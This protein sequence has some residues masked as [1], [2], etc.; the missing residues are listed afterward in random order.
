M[1]RVTLKSENTIVLIGDSP[2]Y[3]TS[4]ETGSLFAGVQDVSFSVPQTRQTQKQLGSCYY[5]VDD[6]V[7]HPDIDLNISYIYSPS[8]VNES[9]M[10]LNVDGIVSTGQPFTQEPSGDFISGIDDKSYN[11]YVYNHPEA[12]FDAIEYITSSDINTPNTGEIVSFGNAYLTQYS[13]SFAN[14]ALPVVQTTFK[15]SNVKAENYTGDI[16]SP[17]INLLSGNNNGVGNIDFSETKTISED[18][19]GSGI[20]LDTT[21]PVLS[22]PKDVTL[23]LQNLQVGGQNISGD[24]IV[25]SLSVSI[26]I[27][28]VD[29][30]GLGSDYVRGRK[31][32]YPSRGSISVAS[33]VSKYETGF[34]SGLLKNES[35]YSFVVTAS[36]CDGEIDSK[37]YFDDVKL[38]TFDYSMQTNENMQYSASFSFTM[39]NK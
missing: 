26:P 16:P 36:S 39:D 8:M 38:E 9:L 1:S 7:R 2:S 14:R 10:G 21:K 33:L 37:M 35:K 12:G 5:A 4:N 30:Y 23:E 6:L 17:A 31:M 28:R 15:C 3:K 32:K 19:Y 22:Q 29:L 11:F 13:F 27:E 25:Q 24:H 18:F 34:I 20:D